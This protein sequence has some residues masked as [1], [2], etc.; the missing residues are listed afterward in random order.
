MHATNSPNIPSM[1]EGNTVP[2][3]EFPYENTTPIWEYISHTS[4]LMWEYCSHMEI[5]VL[6]YSADVEY[7]SHVAEDGNLSITRKN[8]L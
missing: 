7:S 2:I 1:S 3:W 5:P 6:K 8:L 4:V